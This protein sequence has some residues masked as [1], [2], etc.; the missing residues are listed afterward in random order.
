MSFDFKLQN[1]D[2]QLKNGS[3]VKVRDTEKLQQ[4]TTKMLITPKGANKMF[5]FYG[6]LIENIMVGNVFDLEFKTEA[7]TE[8]I[9]NSIDI[10]QSLQKTRSKIQNVTAAETIAALK[11]VSVTQSPSDYRRLQIKVDILSK[12]LVIVSTNLTIQS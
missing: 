8:Q 2:L 5:P 11:N 4:D 7:V 6:S 12:A 3:L 10:L 1:G 9:R